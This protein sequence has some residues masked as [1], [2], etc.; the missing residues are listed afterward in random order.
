M[1]PDVPL[2]DVGLTGVGLA[3]P[4]LASAGLAG[5]PDGR[6]LPPS[7]NGRIHP[8]QTAKVAP[9]GETVIVGHAVVAPSPHCTNWLIVIVRVVAGLA[10]VSVPAAGDTLTTWFGSLA[11]EDDQWTVPPD[12]RSE[13]S[14]PIS[15]GTTIIVPPSGRTDSA[16]GGGLGGGALD[17]GP[18]GGGGGGL[19][20][21]G[22]GLVVVLRGVGLAVAGVAVGTGLV[23]VL[24][25][26]GLVAVV[27]GGG[28][29]VAV[30]GDPPPAV[31][32]G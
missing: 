32:V 30:V 15:P 23:M 31:G 1:P 9:P 21:V 5:V 22:V 6:G 2:P 4:G 18:G 19:G 24:P 25:G 3:C 7:G 26:A 14:E 11:T 20:V 29:A 13:T 17:G 16:P 8:V 12:A 28:P 27:A 10:G